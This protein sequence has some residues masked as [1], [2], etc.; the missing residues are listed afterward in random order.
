[1]HAFVEEVTITPGVE[2]DAVFRL[3][4]GVAQGEG[5]EHSKECRDQDASL[6]HAALD[7][8]RVRG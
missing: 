3:A 1:M 6:L 2:V 7:W 8:E 4:E 5:E